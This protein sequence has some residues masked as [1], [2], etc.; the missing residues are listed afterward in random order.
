M[1]RDKWGMRRTF[2]TPP[3]R[4]A[5]SWRWE[6]G[7]PLFVMGSLTAVLVASAGNAG[8]LFWGAVL[9]AGIGASLFFTGLMRR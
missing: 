9:V 3:G 7:L 4:S 8:A 5:V 1:A 2:S 6:V